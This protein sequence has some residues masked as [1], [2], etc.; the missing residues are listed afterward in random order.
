MSKP[1]VLHITIIVRVHEAVAATNFCC[2][3]GYHCERKDQV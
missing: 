1:L 2:Y 3:R